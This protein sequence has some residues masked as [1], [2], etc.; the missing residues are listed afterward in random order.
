MG[1]EGHLLTLWPEDARDA[2]C[3]RDLAPLVELRRELE[4]RGIPVSIVSAG[5]S[6]TYRTTPTIDGITEIQAGGAC[7][8]DR[9][10]AEECHLEEFSFALTVMTT[11]TSRPTPERVITDAGWK[12]L[13]KGAGGLPSV[14]DRT[15]IEFT[16]LHA[17]HGLARIPEGAASLRVGDTLRL[18]P[19]YSDATIHLYDWIHG[20]RDGR[21]EEMIPV[22]ARGRVA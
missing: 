4:R 5:G 8:M 13:S 14:V 12:A 3:R 21:V 9:F 17:E 20:L 15:E 19:G 16:D 6:G 2:A 1:Y 18:I 22:A 11:V 10:Y 7:L